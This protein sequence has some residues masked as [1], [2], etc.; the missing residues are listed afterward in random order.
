MLWRIARAQAYPTR[1]VRILVGFA[2]GGGGDILARLRTPLLMGIST[3]VEF[4]VA[5]KWAGRTRTS[6]QTGTQTC[7]VMRNRA[8]GG[9]PPR[10]FFP[11]HTRPLWLKSPKPWRGGLLKVGWCS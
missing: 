1:P 9:S 5:H 10:E 11:S 2:A 6:N 3:K 7:A 8:C 4:P